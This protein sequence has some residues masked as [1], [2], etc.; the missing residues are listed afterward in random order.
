M[1]G[2]TKLEQFTTHLYSRKP[3]IAEKKNE[4]KKQPFESDLPKS[5]IPEIVSSTIVKVTSTDS[6]T[7]SN[8]YK[9]FCSPFSPLHNIV[10]WLTDRPTDWLLLISLCEQRDANSIW[11]DGQQI[12]HYDNYFCETFSMK[13]IL[14][15]AP[16]FN[17]D[18]FLITIGEHSEYIHRFAH[19][20]CP[21]CAINI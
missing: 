5:S 12:F 1:P 10:N 13:Q 18:F 8:I 3:C 7:F 15:L 11:W 9:W 17:I 14:Y 6:Q 2:A 16:M 4:T 20:K 21:L 19:K